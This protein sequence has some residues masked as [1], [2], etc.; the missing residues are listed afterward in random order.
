MSSG[1][2]MYHSRSRHRTNST[3]SGSED[4]MRS[5]PETC[6]PDTVEH[7]SRHYDSRYPKG[8]PLEE[9]HF[10]LPR[11]GCFGPDSWNQKGFPREKPHPDNRHM[12]SHYLD[13]R[14][15]DGRHA[16]SRPPGNRHPDGHLS[17]R[18]RTHEAY[19]QEYRACGEDRRSYMVPPH[20]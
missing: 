20:G 3:G 6:L 16:E 1:M 19:D 13:N 14:R 17:D 11:S 15:P 18:S 12:D 2:P 9:H 7:E 8:L 5:N 4:R 10:D